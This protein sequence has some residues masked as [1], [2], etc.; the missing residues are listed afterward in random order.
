MEELSRSQDR[1]SQHS[2]ASWGD[3]VHPSPKVAVAEQAAGGRIRCR[4]PIRSEN[5]V[6]RPVIRGLVSLWPY[7]EDT[8]GGEDIRDKQNVV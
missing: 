3:R 1:D 6:S 4:E 8:E 2:A 5:A 7:E